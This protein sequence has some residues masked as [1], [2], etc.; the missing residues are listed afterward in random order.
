MPEPYRDPVTVARIMDV[1]NRRLFRDRIVQPARATRQL[2]VNNDVL[3]DERFVAFWRTVA[4]KTRYLVEFD[5]E[6]L[7]AACVS[8]IRNMP[9][10]QPPRII[11]E[12][13]NI[14]QSYAGISEAPAHYVD[15]I[16]SAAVQVLPD[17]ITMI[18]SETNLTR[19]TIS[20]ILVE[21]DRLADFERNPQAFITATLG[22]IKAQLNTCLMDGLT[23][24]KVDGDI[25]HVRELSRRGW[26]AV[27]DARNPLFEP[28]NRSRTVWDAIPLDSGTERTFVQ[29]LDDDTRVKYY[30]KLPAWFTVDTPIGQYNPDWA[31]LYEDE[32]IFSLVRETKSSTDEQ[33][34]R[35]AENQK[36]QAARA[37]FKAID[38]DYDDV[39][40]WDQVVASLQN[41]TNS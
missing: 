5:T 35:V 3:D 15:M 37:H 13:A 14:D 19:R 9:S 6:R 31:I 18:Q 41:K 36:I 11:V 1:I 26:S 4:Q 17:V 2:R 10:I 30:V 7:I 32:E 16:A 33:K 28:T 39:V 22:I 40:T 34:R 23:Y 27:E 25:W 20:R 8:A 29:R 21:S 38:V 12:I 24:E